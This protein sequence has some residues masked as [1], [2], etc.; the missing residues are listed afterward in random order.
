M[1]EVK[2]RFLCHGIMTVPADQLPPG[3][4]EMEAASKWNWLQEWWETNVTDDVLKA[5]LIT[6]DVPYDPAPGLLEENDGEEYHTV[7]QS[8]EY[9]EWWHSDSATAMH[10]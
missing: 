9:F 4:H 5:G 8:N 1:G 3:W 2:V 7:A 10:E 6:D